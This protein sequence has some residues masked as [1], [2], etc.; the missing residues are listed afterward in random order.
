M[1]IAGKVAFV[2]GAGSGIGRAAVLAFVHRGAKVIVTDV[3]ECT[4]S[5]QLRQSTAVKKREMSHRVG[6][7]ATAC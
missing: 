3:D 6:I 2:S 1:E 5:E 7:Q 4:S